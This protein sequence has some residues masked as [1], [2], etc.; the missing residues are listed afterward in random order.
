MKEDILRLRSIGYTYNEIQ[1]ELGCSKGTISYHLGYG[2]KQ[3]TKARS[4]K[5]REEIRNLIRSH[6]EGIPCNDCGIL[7]PYYIMDFDHVEDNKVENISKMAQW[8]SIEEILV[9]IKKCEIVCSNCHRQR[10][11]DRK[12]AA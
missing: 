10:T 5:R 4:Q 3:K 12:N 9:E 2:Q 1:K 8:Y 6:K 7:Y 11:Y